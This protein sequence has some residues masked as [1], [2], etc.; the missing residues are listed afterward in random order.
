VLENRVLG[1]IVKPKREEV[2]V[3][4]IKSHNEERTVINVYSYPD[5]I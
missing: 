1:R 4:G 5:V 2:T 3:G